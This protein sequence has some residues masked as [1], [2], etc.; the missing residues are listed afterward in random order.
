MSKA[1][2]HIDGNPLFKVIYP[3]GKPI[4]AETDFRWSLPKSG[5]PGKWAKINP[6]TELEMCSTGFHLTTDP[7]GQ[8]YKWGAVVYSAEGRGFAG[9]QDDKSLFREA[10]LLELQPRPDWLTAAYTFVETE[11]ANVRWLKPD[12]DPDPV[13]KLFPTRDAASGAARGAAWDAAWGAAR[14]A[15]WD[16]ARGAARGAAWDAARD[17]ELKVQTDFICDGLDIDQRHRD[18][19]EARWNVWRKGY[20]LL[21]DVDGVLYVYEKV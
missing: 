10:R 6:E 14:D 15:A 12:G 3:D 16:A 13:W 21:C 1:I 4:V 2:S 9:T 11:I 20:G 5:K 19:A 7:Y 18:H 8:W 17:A